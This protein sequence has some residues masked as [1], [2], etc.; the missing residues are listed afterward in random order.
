MNVQPSEKGSPQQCL[1]VIF[2]LEAV[3][4]V[5]ETA[6]I[7][8]RLL[9]HWLF[10]VRRS[11]SVFANLFDVCVFQGSAR[12]NHFCLYINLCNIAKPP[13]KL[14]QELVIP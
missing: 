3:M 9:L 7:V 12:T 5:I 2:I 8:L 4:Q 10:I 6:V 1:S 13:H 14:V 11:Y